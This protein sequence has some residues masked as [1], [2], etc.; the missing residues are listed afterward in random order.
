MRANRIV[1]GLT[2]AYAT[3]LAL[4][5]LVIPHH[6]DLMTEIPDAHGQ[7]AVVR[8]D[9]NDTLVGALIMVGEGALIGLISYT[10]SLLS[11]GLLGGLMTMGLAT[12]VR[13][14]LTY[15]SA[16]GLA[17]VIA[18]LS[19]STAGFSDSI[20]VL[21]SMK[22]R[23]GKKMKTLIK[24]LVFSMGMGALPFISVIATSGRADPSSVRLLV[25]DPALFSALAMAAPIMA[26]L[27][28]GRIKL[29]AWDVVL[30]AELLTLP[31][32]VLYRLAPDLLLL[33]PLFGLILT[34]TTPMEK[35]G[36]RLRST[37]PELQ[38]PEPKSRTPD[39]GLA[40]SRLK[41]EGEG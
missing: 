15:E 2:I 18:T 1:C 22:L 19:S 26:F 14:P 38:F 8:L 40:M 33:G 20:S 28:T 32:A 30:A 24:F 23:R 27:R 16:V 37:V 7:A 9:S 11:F 4:S 17:T 31:S 41:E 6:G 39:L 29:S 34:L 10:S 13:A 12:A 25:G 5:L 36:P 21:L 35:L 3:V